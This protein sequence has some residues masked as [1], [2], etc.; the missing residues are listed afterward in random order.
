[1]IAEDLRAAE[2][3]LDWREQRENLCT[4]FFMRLDTLILY[5]SPRQLRSVFAKN[6]S[7]YRLETVIL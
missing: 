2:N 1:M 7:L 6:D 4:T 5:T 3:L